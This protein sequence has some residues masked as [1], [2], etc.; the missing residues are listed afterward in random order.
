MKPPFTT[1]QILTCLLSEDS[2]WESAEGADDNPPGPCF[3]E[4]VTCAGTTYGPTGWEVFLYEYGTNPEDSFNVYGYDGSLLFT[5]SN[6]QKT[7]TVKEW[8]KLLNSR[9]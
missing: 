9:K 6:K 5:V 1:G 4:E 8:K 2:E 3:G 7:H